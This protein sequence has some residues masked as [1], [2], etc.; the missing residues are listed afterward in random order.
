MQREKLNFHN[1][2]VPTPM[3]QGTNTWSA[4]SYLKEAFALLVMLSKLQHHNT[5]CDGT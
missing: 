5:A 1:N 3:G 4:K 2:A